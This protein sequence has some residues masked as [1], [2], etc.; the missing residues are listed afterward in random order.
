MIRESTFLES[1]LLKVIGLTTLHPEDDSTDEVLSQRQ[2]I[3]SLI[4]ECK[5]FPRTLD[6]TMPLLG[7]HAWASLSREAIRARDYSSNF[8]SLRTIQGQDALM[9]LIQEQLD[10]YHNGTKQHVDGA[11]HA[12]DPRIDVKEL[13]APVIWLM[14]ILQGQCH[15]QPALIAQCLLD[16]P[17]ALEAMV[18]NMPVP[19]DYTQSMSSLPLQGAPLG[20]PPTP[21]ST[22]ALEFHLSLTSALLRTLLA[23]SESQPLL[24]P[25]FG[26]MGGIGLC[27][28]LLD[29][30]RHAKS[31]KEEGDLWDDLV[32]LASALLSQLLLQ[33]MEESLAK[34]ASPDEKKDAIPRPC[35]PWN[36]SSVGICPKEEQ[37]ERMVSFAK[38]CG[39]LDQVS[40]GLV[41]TFQ[42]RYKPP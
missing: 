2:E 16:H 30:S 22:G 12:D 32:L 3:R 11:G 29:S 10:V 1:F 6:M 35:I 42:C 37:W 15:A 14:D 40:S 7:L 24:L 27:I 34:I 33:P 28:D 8:L 5:I 23:L 21:L 31:R 17:R 26:S 25:V 39:S 19:A 13:Y 4:K 36:P 18:H 20:N 38:Y 9:T 41:Y